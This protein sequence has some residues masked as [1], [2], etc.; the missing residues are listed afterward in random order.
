MS[1]EIGRI[2]PRR[3]SQYRDEPR[4]MRHEWIRAERRDILRSADHMQQLSRYVTELRA[5][6]DVPDFDPLDGGEE[7]KVLF[8]QEKPG[9][10]TSGN[11]G[12]GFISMNND[13]ATATNSFKFLQAIGIPREAVVFWNAMPWWDGTIKYTR[14]ELIKGVGQV[15]GLLEHL[16]NLRA[17]V[18]V[19]VP[20][21]KAASDIA[22][23]RPDVKIFYSYHPSGINHRNHP[24]IILD[25]SL[26]KSYLD[27]C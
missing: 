10:K 19:G 18:L 25:W 11:N 26:V 15:R 17:V 23:C 2:S 16:P 22:R 21:R 1:I 6:G 14:H 5:Y 3:S 8:L 13:D 27:T 4:S 9:P 7:A 20:A 24:S 12:S